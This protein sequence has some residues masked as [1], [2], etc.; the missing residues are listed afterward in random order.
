MKDSLRMIGISLIF[1]GLG[2]RLMK[3]ANF[4]VNF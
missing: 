4:N 2:V 3:A 1:F